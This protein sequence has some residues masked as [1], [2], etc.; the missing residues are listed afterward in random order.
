MGKA[1]RTK[2][3]SSRREKIAAQRAAANLQL[4]QEDERWGIEAARERKR[5]PDRGKTAAPP[6]NLI[7]MGSVNLREGA[8]TPSTK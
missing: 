3:D 7:P 6:V 5:A 1:S 2:V 8:Q 4:E